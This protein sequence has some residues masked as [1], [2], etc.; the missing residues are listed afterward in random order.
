MF[1]PVNFQLFGRVCQ[2]FRW[3]AAAFRAT[4]RGSHPG[5]LTYPSRLALRSLGMKRKMLVAAAAS[6]LIM[7][8]ACSPADE[9]DDTTTNSAAG[10]LDE[11]QVDDLELVEPGT[12]TI[13]TDD[14]AYP[15]WFV[16]DDPSNGEGYEGAV[17]YAVAEQL[18]FSADDV[19]WVVA[20]FNQAVQPGTK[21]FDFDI[22]Q[23]SITEE[24]AESV[25]F[26]SPYYSAAQAVI[27]LEDSEFAD[28]SS[29]SDLAEAQLGA[30]VGTTS[31]E[32]VDQIGPDADPL[33][34]D[35]TSLAA[36]ALQNGQVDG[37]LADLPTAFYLTAAE[38]DG[39]VIAG[40]FQP[41]TG[42][43]EEFGLL[44]ELN[45]PL[46]D[47]VSLAVDALREDGTLAALEEEWLS[48]QTDVPELD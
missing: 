34:Y 44:L 14:P 41:I 45:S 17:A 20:G 24:R 3:R 32:A 31:L 27:V 37:I 8:A 23:F 42:E 22:N 39:A 12:L 9:S 46:T 21:N 10:S 38:L 36:Q 13:A 47:C 15:P 43:S 19:A 30:Q 35:N 5:Q 40:Q 28:V 11:C 26:S 1:L 16:D 29:L 7:A 33:V 48:D 2:L 18:G 6:A 4:R 25:D